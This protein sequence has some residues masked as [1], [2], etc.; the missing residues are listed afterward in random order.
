MKRH[1]LSAV[2]LAALVLSFSA[3]AAKL[4]KWVDDN[5][6]THYGE[7]IPPEYAGKERS[8][9]N[10]SGRIVEKRKVQSAEERR[11][12]AEA[13][14]KKRVDDNAAL[15]RKRHDTS[16]VNTF[17][18][19]KE[20]DLARNRSLQ[21]IATRLDSINSQQKKVEANIATLQKEAD[22]YK[23]SGKPIP[24]SLEEDLKGS[25]VRLSKLQQDMDKALAEKAAIDA[26]YDAD[27][28]RYKELTG[29]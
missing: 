4:Y 23:L 14:A 13:E 6:V 1:K 7:T 19:E 27:K 11:A 20:I 21:Q 2:L 16:L 18:N 15:E 29:K 26:R 3:E 10:Q 28:V 17:S 9:L 22:S 25:H 24:S 5:G 12:S 8:E